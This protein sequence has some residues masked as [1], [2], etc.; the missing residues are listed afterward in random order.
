MFWLPYLSGADENAIPSYPSKLDLKRYRETVHPVL[1][2]T[3][4]KCHSA[5]KPKGGFRI[6]NLDPD[7]ENGKD[8]EKWEEVLNQ[9]QTGTMPPKSE[10]G[11]PD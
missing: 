10:K 4:V 1:Q 9:M 5:A 11:R 3:C 6:D 8:A 2:N 7:L